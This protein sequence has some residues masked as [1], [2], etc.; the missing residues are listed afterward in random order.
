MFGDQ[1]LN[2]GLKLEVWDSP[3]SAGIVIDAVRLAKPALDGGSSARSR[4]RA[5]T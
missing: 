5:P 1:L 2:V 3:S 4:P